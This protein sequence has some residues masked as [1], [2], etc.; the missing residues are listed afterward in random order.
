MVAVAYAASRNLINNVPL[1]QNHRIPVTD[2]RYDQPQPN[3]AG[4]RL[5]CGAYADCITL[6]STRGEYRRQLIANLVLRG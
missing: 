5:R 1:P 4:D 2:H 3:S 6:T